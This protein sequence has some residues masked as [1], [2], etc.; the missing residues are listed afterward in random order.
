M[1][2]TRVENLNSS[3]SMNHEWAHSIP[4][5]RRSRG[6]L[7]SLLPVPASRHAAA[8][9]LGRTPDLDKAKMGLGG[10]LALPADVVLLL[11]RSRWA[12]PVL[13]VWLVIVGLT[14]Y[15]Q[16]LAATPL[17]KLVLSPPEPS[18][19][20]RFHKAEFSV[21][22]TRQYANPYD[23]EEV[24][25]S[26]E[27]TT[28]SG[29]KLNVPA[30]FEQPYERLLLDRSGRKAEW[31]YP[32]GQ[33]CW[34]VRYTPVEV[35]KHLAA[36]VLQEPAGVHR[37]APVALE[38]VVAPGRG[39]VRVS[40]QDAR[41][42]ELDDGS[43]FFPIG[44]NVAFIGES[45]HL[46]TERARE[47]FR[48]MA[49]QGANF[50]RV[51][52]CAED[53]ALAIE[54]KRSAW[55]RSWGGKTPLVPTPQDGRDDT[56]RLC[57]GLGGAQPAQVTVSPTRPLAV[58][59]GVTYRLSGAVMTEAGSGLTIEPA[60]GAASARLGSDTPRQW[61]VFAHTFETGA[62]QRWLGELRLRCS[63]GGSVWLRDLS[64]REAGG[65]PE[66]LGEA[67]PNRLVRG[68]YHQHDSQVLDQ[69]VEA[70]AQHGIYLQLCLL[71]RDLY[72]PFLR[73][74][75]SPEY[76]AAVSDA[77]KFF[78]HAVARWGYSPQVFAWEYFNEN[79][80]NL[81][82]ELF[83][84]EVGF[85]LEATD[86][87]RHLRTTSGWGPAPRHWQHPQLDMA[88]LHWYLRPV[89]KPDWR[90]EVAAILDR[91]ALLRSHATNKPALLG[92]FGLADDK[93]GRSPY[94]PRDKAGVHFRQAL[95]A[96]AFAGLSGTAMFWWW[97]TLDQNDL[98]PHYRPLAN[99]LAG[100][101]FTTAAFQSLTLST[102]KQA[103]VLAWRGR[104]QACLWIHHPQ[105][106]WWNAVA[107]NKPVPHSPEDALTLAGLA[108]GNYDVEW[109]D[110]KSGQVTQ[111][112]RT[113]SGAEGL[114]LAVPPYTG[115]VACKLVR[116]REAA[117][118]R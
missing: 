96:S 106:T 60:T 75:Q 29:A 49:A 18:T 44:Q 57:I 28:P 10:S 11:R 50:A 12:G 3:L 32:T 51:W 112:A 42:F 71:T 56:N 31:L 23:P 89:S 98:Y 78:R 113:G 77:Q 72:R 34:R 46:D 73:D 47:V 4:V 108:P 21:A 61:K 55:G 82:S 39:F 19:V 116:Q 93:W 95:W 7:T 64:L 2:P 101:P 67:D 20:G 9:A 110:T 1:V 84:R 100:V 13:T 68:L 102:E 83:H 37:S 6:A 27:V 86:P 65:G 36:A 118:S 109:W 79:D 103:R 97:E 30:F 111:R 88:D 33:P 70:A 43:P 35:G 54:A 41:F 52:A 63:G 45:Q 80:P 94:M 26:L 107:E 14:S 85:F 48:K 115:D 74:P 81:P 90:D 16:A 15:A 66:L 104:D 5:G 17:E 22:W 105:A 117:P 38:C 62:N 8:L 40:K 76:R 87:Y 25:L 69:I 58:K 53:W 24:A 91:A 114:R 92:E 99:Y 59:P